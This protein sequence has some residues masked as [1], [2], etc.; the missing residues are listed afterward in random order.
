MA[1]ARSAGQTPAPGSIPRALIGLAPG[2]AL[3][4][5]ISAAAVWLQ[6]LEAHA[7]GRPYVEALVIAILLGGLIRSLWQPSEIWRAGVVLSAKTLLEIAV[8]LLG[9]SISFAA[10]VASGPA[11][12]AGIAI[13][14]VAALARS[15]ATS[16]ALGLPRRVSIL[17]LRQLDLRQFG[18]R[19]GRANHWRG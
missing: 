12:L 5:G 11:L 7:F 6:D 15:Y 4:A 19:R 18:D 13:T 8:T 10:I 1:G 3:C 16:R 17:M 9:A 2:L 14:V